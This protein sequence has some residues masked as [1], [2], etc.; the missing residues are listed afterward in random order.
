MHLY[1]MHIFQVTYN[2]YLHGPLTMQN[3][4]NLLYIYLM[5]STVQ[6]S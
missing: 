6:A 2:L 1:I 4:L 3:F 5:S